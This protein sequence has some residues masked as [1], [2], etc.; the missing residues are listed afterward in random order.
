MYMRVYIVF[1]REGKLCLYI[2]EVAVGLAKSLLED[3]ASSSKD[4]VTIR[5]QLIDNGIMQLNS[6]VIGLSEYLSEVVWSN[7]LSEID[8]YDNELKQFAAN[9]VSQNS[10]SSNHLGSQISQWQEK[11]PNPRADLGE[12]CLNKILST[13]YLEVDTEGTESRIVLKTNR[14]QH[15]TG[16]YLSTGTKQ[17][18]STSIPIYKLN[19][20]NGA[21]LFDEPERSLFPDIQRILVQHYVSLAPTAQFFFAT[22]SPIIASA[23]EPEERFILYF[24]ENGDVKYRKGVAPEG[25]DPNDILSEDF[26]L[27]ELMLDKG[28]EAYAEHRNLAVAI[29]NEKDPQRK[30][31]LIVK[32]AKLGDSYKF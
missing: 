5:G 13:L 25:D 17:L 22:H 32:R 27:E 10:F 19:L 18:L 15:I 23:F 20:S 28:L 4:L 16:K 1:L 9:L 3:K 2:D 29:R 6:P 30:E 12:N 8:T 31:E 14:G 21:V 7:L 24:D 26:G 11:H